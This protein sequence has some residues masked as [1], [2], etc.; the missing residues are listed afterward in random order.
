MKKLVK[1][2]RK[3]KMEIVFKIVKC[4]LNKKNDN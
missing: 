4:L 3:L 2:G 1:N